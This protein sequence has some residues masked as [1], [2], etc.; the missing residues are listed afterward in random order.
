MDFRAAEHLYEHCKQYGIVVL[1]DHDQ[2]SGQFVFFPARGFQPAAVVIFPGDI[3]MDKEIDKDEFV[4]ILNEKPG[5]ADI[6]MVK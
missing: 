6:N 3:P 5:T 2:V 1:N 4:K